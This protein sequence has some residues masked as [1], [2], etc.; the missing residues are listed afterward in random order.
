MTHLVLLG[1]VVDM[2]RRDA[3]GVF[4]ENRDTFDKIF[5]L[6]DKGVKVSYVAGNHDYH[7][8]RLQ[9]H[10]YQ[11]VFQSEL[12]LPD[13]ENKVSYRFVHG[14]QFDLEQQEAWMEGLCRLMSDQAGEFESG[15]WAELTRGW[16]N[17]KYV[18]YEMFESWKKQSMRKMAD[19]VQ[20][21][22]EARFGG[23]NQHLLDEINKRACASVGRDEVLI[24]GHTHVPFVNKSENVANCG[25]WVKDASTGDT[26][27]ELTNG[28]PHLFTF[29]RK[30]ITE[31]KEC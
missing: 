27:V 19:R 9:N 31:R 21:Q 14:Y 2:W 8:L 20:Q 17:P 12:S 5:A 1:D 7:V 26:Y 16:S 18:L 4:L 10:S 30:E 23:V 24:F 25:S 28:K 22:P 6:C 15:L 3:S 11:F 29:P 13:D